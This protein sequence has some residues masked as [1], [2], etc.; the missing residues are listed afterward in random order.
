MGHQAGLSS[1]KTKVKIIYWKN[2]ICRLSLRSIYTEYSVVQAH[3]TLDLSIFPVA[4]QHRFI[5][6]IDRRNL[7]SIIPQFVQR[8]SHLEDLT[9][10]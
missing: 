1:R 3:L 5:D 6:G 8:L 7:Q 10:E 4:C 9:A 2:A